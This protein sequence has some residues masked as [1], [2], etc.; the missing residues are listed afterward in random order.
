M[1]VYVCVR[2]RARVRV[3]HRKMLESPAGG[4]RMRTWERVRSW[5]V[6]AT[7]KKSCCEY[8][9]WPSINSGV[10]V[11]NVKFVGNIER[12]HREVMRV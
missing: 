7:K 2:A 9:G 5:L 1:R 3:G 10:S 4:P 12:Y 8:C 11:D 6:A